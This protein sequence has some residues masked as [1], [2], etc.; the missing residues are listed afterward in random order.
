M[1]ENILQ[2]YLAAGETLISNLLLHHYKEL[3]LTTSQLVL[4]LTIESRTKT[5]GWLI[6][7]SA[8]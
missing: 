1:A 5:R 7:I 6:P 4:Y 8:K 3:G 2:R